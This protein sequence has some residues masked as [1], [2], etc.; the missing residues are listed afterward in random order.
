MS[1]DAFKT[2]VTHPATMTV[3]VVAMLVS[4]AITI[5][6]LRANNAH[7]MPL[8]KAVWALTVLYSGPLGLLVYW[9]CGRKEIADD[10]VWRRAFRS[11]CHCYS[12]CGAGEITGVV[13]AAGL[14]ALSSNWWLA[15]I[16]FAFAYVF[17]YAMTVGPMV[18]EGVGWGEAM[19]DA[20][21]AE[22]PSITVM[23]VTAIGVDIWLAGKATF[24]EPLFWASLVISL[25]CGLFVAY[26]VNWLLI[27]F[28]IKEGMMDPRNT[29]HA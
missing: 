20:L 9:T 25:S 6:D 1:L 2:F 4:L 10:S 28:G 27:R 11:V 3:W 16:T 12:G 23:E 29:A 17:G 24:G 14:L 18:Q 7:L 26:P 22:T 19:W 5:R 8:M 15:G 21:I 13:I